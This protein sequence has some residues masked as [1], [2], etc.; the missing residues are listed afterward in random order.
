MN[1]PLSVTTLNIL[2]VKPPVTFKGSSIIFPKLSSL[3]ILLKNKFVSMIT[4]S[5]LIIPLILQI[6]AF[7]LEILIIYG[8]MYIE[9]DTSMY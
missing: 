1:L 5:Y 7:V 9:I 3:T 4:T 2:C 8:K 6:L